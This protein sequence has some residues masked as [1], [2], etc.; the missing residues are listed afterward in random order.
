M[1]VQ[2]HE[3]WS[4]DINCNPDQLRWA[5]EDSHLI[6]KNMLERDYSL[7]EEKQDTIKMPAIDR[8]K[9]PSITTAMPCFG[10]APGPATRTALRAF[11]SP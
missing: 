1:A 6:A 8:F 7:Y 2:H 10:S 11:A 4:R 3:R 9:N 5:C